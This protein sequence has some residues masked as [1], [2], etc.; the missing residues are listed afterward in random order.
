VEQESDN[1]ELMTQYLLGELSEEECVKVETR[2]LADNE[3]FEQLLAVEDALID[4]YLLDNLPPDQRARV[5]KLV[6]SSSVQ[7]REMELARDL[8]ANISEKGLSLPPSTADLSPD[9]A[10]IARGQFLG[11]QYTPAIWVTWLALLACLLAWNI[12][13]QIGKGRIEGEQTA[14]K[15]ENQEYQRRIDGEIKRN[16]A[17][18]AQLEEEKNKLAKSEQLVAELQRNVSPFNDNEIITINL[19]S[20]SESRN[21]GNLKVISIKANTRRIRLQLDIEQGKDYKEYSVGINTFENRPVWSKN[22]ITA[23]QLKS[24]KLIL[25][26]PA[27]ILPVDDYTIALRARAENGKLEEIANYSFSIRKSN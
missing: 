17:I 27:N 22:S 14:L 25:V 26:L 19:S 18:T 16:E 23:D 12:Y 20:D 1:N 6:T 24:N 7:Q 21:E 4:E 13:L 2:F 10:E 15:T 11:R 3:F 5:E 9:Q 8:I